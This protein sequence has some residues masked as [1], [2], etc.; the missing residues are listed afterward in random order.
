MI[1]LPFEPGE[2][3][4]PRRLPE[5]EEVH[6]WWVDLN[7]SESELAVARGLLDPEEIQRAERFRFERHRRRFIMRRAQ[8][9]RLLGHYLQRDA[10]TLRFELGE[11]GKPRL[12]ADQMAGLPST[13]EFNLSDSADVAVVG[14]Q[15]DQELGVD[16]EVVR[17]MKDAL[18]ISKHFFAESEQRTLAAQPSAEVDRTFFRCWTR[19]EAYIKAIGK[20][21]ALPLDSFMVSMAPDEAPSFLGFVGHPGEES[22]WS[23]AHLE[24]RPGVFV[25][26]A[27]RRPG[28]RI[29]GFVAPVPSTW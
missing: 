19:K 7:A 1:E 16:V 8:L 13:L 25:A 28:M 2:V 22:Q 5:A 21:L 3:S 12:A 6:L 26:V 17:E 18:A 9:R 27:A 10:S 24:P 23:L 15:L 4:R 20:G 11:R 14:V 29:S